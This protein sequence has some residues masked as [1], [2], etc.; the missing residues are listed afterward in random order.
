ME[1]NS[2]QQKLFDLGVELYEHYEKGIL[3]SKDTFFD[4]ARMSLYKSVLA[5]SICHED[6]KE[7]EI[8][9]IEELGDYEKLLDSLQ[10]NHLARRYYQGIQNVSPII[11]ASVITDFKVTM[12]HFF[13]LIEKVFE[14][15]EKK[16]EIKNDNNGE[17][18]GNLENVKKELLD[19][20]DAGKLKAVACGIYETTGIPASK[21]TIKGML[22]NVDLERLKL[23]RTNWKEI[24]DNHD[25]WMESRKELIDEILYWY[26][27]GEIKAVINTFLEMEELQL[28]DYIEVRNFIRY[29][30]ENRSLQ[31][32]KEF[33]EMCESVK[34]NQK[35][36]PWLEQKPIMYFIDEDIKVIKL[37]GNE[38]GSIINP[39]FTD[40]QS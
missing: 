29:E 25:D 30:L 11:K 1:L 32:I 39:L 31:G 40:S 4:A 21:D 8:K 15:N 18:N 27:H 10:D 13:S 35:V 28:N 37:N 6:L 12:Q 36:K 14:Q 24:A 16:L 9:K 19:L 38:N 33:H 20:Y 2:K 26:D 34:I 17:N 5:L 23:I 22:E 7:K 3:K